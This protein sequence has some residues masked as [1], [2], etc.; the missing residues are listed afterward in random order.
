MI[1]IKDYAVVTV[2]TCLST[3]AILFTLT[4]PQQTQI[5]QTP[6]GQYYQPPIQQPVAPESPNITIQIPSYLDYTAT[7]SQLKI[8][9][10][11]AKDLTEVDTY[12][13][14]AKGISLYYIRVTNKLKV[15][16]KPKVLITACIHGNE[17]LSASTIMGYI[18]TMLERY[19]KDQRITELIDTR[20]IYFVP[21]ISPDS[22]PQS[23]YVN[24]VDP[25]RDFPGPKNPD[26][27]SVP[28][29]AA[30]QN[31]FKQIK[32]N[33]VIS[34]HTWGRVYLIPWGD[35][36]KTSPNEDDYQKIIGEMGRL[37]G[38]KI[39]HACQMYNRPIFGTEIDWYY[40]NGAFAI[41]MEFGTHQ[42]IPSQSDIKTEFEMTFTAIQ[43]FIQEAPL[44]EIK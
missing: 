3:L 15:K 21:V 31:L 26:K 25:N 12:G 9:N 22:Y 24:G 11:E 34:G 38:Y 39:K 6:W 14:S 32:P 18:G 40:R 36:T 37:S 20:D 43:H 33:A 27:K 7:V 19:G 42:N 44:V 30:I 13:K 35:Q 17:P 1:S 10:Q 29:V 2:A 41:V 28:P 16:P 4:P 23:R 5:T 8:W